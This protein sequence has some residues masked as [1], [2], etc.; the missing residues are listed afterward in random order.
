MLL[1]MAKVHVKC[2]GTK[3]VYCNYNACCSNVTFIQP[4]LDHFWLQVFSV[5]RQSLGPTASLI[6]RVF[7]SLLVRPYGTGVS[8]GC[9]GGGCGGDGGVWCGGGVGV[10]C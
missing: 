10:V 2:N 5:L 1:V 3:A 4:R 6:V 9:D 7:Q 8:G